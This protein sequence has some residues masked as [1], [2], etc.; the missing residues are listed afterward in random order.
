[1]RDIKELCILLLGFNPWLLFLFLA[2]H[3]MPS[4]KIAIIIS[5]AR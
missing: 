5:L 2:G 3:S 4:L 1:M